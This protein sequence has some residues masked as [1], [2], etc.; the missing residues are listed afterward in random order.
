[1]P[2]DEGFYRDQKTLHVVFFFSSAALLAATLWMFAADHFLPWKRW[3]REFN[4]VVK[5]EKLQ[6]ELS[7][8]EQELR[9]RR[10]EI[11]TL[12]QRLAQARASE[13][14]NA[15][16]TQLKS[17]LASLD[18]DLV[19]QDMA[20]QFAKADR[21]EALSAYDRVVQEFE[22]SGEIDVA[23]R[24]VLEYRR[25]QHYQTF[26]DH[27]KRVA[28]L[29]AV[30][31]AAKRQIRE[32]QDRL[33]KLEKPRAQI[34][35]ELK[36]KQ[37]Q[38]RKLERAIESTVF[39][40]GARL[41]GL[42]ILDAFAAPVKPDQ[43]VLEDL[44]L[45]YNFKYVTRHDRCRTCH[46]GIDQD[47]YT[48]EMG[49]KHPFLSHPH[50]DL[51]VGAKSP[52][53]F[54]KFG[55]TICH[56]GQGTA[57]AF[58]WS[59]HSPN[60]S[61]QMK[62]WHQRHGWFFNHFHELPMFP[63]RFTESGCIQCHHDPHQFAVAEEKYGYAIG[64]KVLLGYETVRTYGCFGCHEISGF[65]DDGTAI[66]PHLR[67]PLRT[68][69]PPMRRRALRRVGP[70]LMNVREKLTE[71]FVQK[72][73]RDPLAFRPT[74]RMPTFY[75]QLDSG[76]FGD[77]PEGEFDQPHDPGT[78]ASVEIHAIGKYLFALSEPTNY[79]PIGATGNAETGKKL[80]VE[81][82]CLACHYHKEHPPGFTRVR[83]PFAPELSEIGAKFTTDSQKR[84]LAAW[85][86]DPS[87]FNPET[88]MPNTQLTDQEAADIAAYLLGVPG[89]WQKNVSLPEL[90]RAALRDLIVM[91]ESKTGSRAEANEVAGDV[92]K[93]RER[94]ARLFD[95]P[96]SVEPPPPGQGIDTNDLVELQLLY[97]GHKTIARLGCFGCHAIPG[98]KYERDKSGNLI[99][100]ADGSP[101][102]EL[103]FDNTKPIGTTLN[104][105]GRKDTHQLAFENV[106]EYV[107]HKMEAH[108]ENELPAAEREFYQFYAD[109]DYYLWAMHEHQRDGF[110]MQKLREPR[111]Y[112]YQKVR[113]WDD[114][115]RMP[116]F[117]FTD[118]QRE[119][120]AT[121]I[122]GLFAEKLP[123]Q[124]IYAP[125]PRTQARIEGR[126]LL[127]QYNCV[128]C[129]VIRPAEYRATLSAEAANSLIATAKANLA[130]DFSFPGHSA[131]EAKPLNSTNS[132]LARGL[133]AGRLVDTEQG[134]SETR[135]QLWEATSIGNQHIPAGMVVL[136][137][138]DSQRPA[139]F[140]PPTGG[141]FALELVEHLVRQSPNPENPEERDKAWQ[142]A[143]PPLIREGEKV[144]TPWLYGFLKDPVEIRP[145]TLLRMPK[146]NFGQGHA[147]ALAD[148]FAAADGVAYPYA[149]VAE[150]RESYLIERERQY[151]NY[152][153]LGLRLVAHKD[154]CVKCHPIAGY[155]PTGKPEEKGPPLTRAHERLRPDWML[156]WIT[157]PKRLVP[158]TQM[159]VNFQKSGEG[160]TP[161]MMAILPT[162]DQFERIR[163]VRDVL[164]NY[165]RVTEDLIPK[166]QVAAATEQK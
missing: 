87:A 135:V 64:R 47:G 108:K 6:D 19:R 164:V 121:F 11:A 131:W 145:G 18:A 42:P 65:A 146:F 70:T 95:L 67:L 23:R 117:N 137:P 79:Q 92:G 56:Q 132:L 74:T 153:Q 106:V 147:E 45:N 54:E 32:R 57:T 165:P 3:Q 85:I 37:D 40:P 134:A 34:E 75:D 155:Q 72:W 143:P 93:L 128:A 80:F 33:E 103:V 51:F 20:V 58:D 8:Q 24:A 144:Q 53:K 113:R 35:E 68:D 112:D 91:F 31:D 94:I 118:E 41:R 5:R 122:L 30:V 136:L 25:D 16:I 13:A 99:P 78:L 4:S 166:P 163:A 21:Q 154:L 130:A 97:V 14:N 59:S 105:W 61:R 140:A 60:D 81:K 29:Q 69:S 111:S 12:E 17:E 151:K 100:V 161:D 1:M 148:Y 138:D 123:R 129:H 52:H 2:A 114:R 73:I 71:E 48:A 116:R 86:K 149:E 150:R 88:Y 46:V 10:D 66:G 101:R 139:Q 157:N 82:G 55:C 83:P 22:G 84:W 62:E 119:S 26:L 125:D 127:E 43:V 98:R 63:K 115:A 39:T 96:G 9:T 162:N 159:P 89:R 120:V 109:N 38:K 158:Y 110:L 102:Y 160:M 27:E 152:L 126:R 90:D 15:E 104:N 133:F 142:K 44:R 49:L 77:A 28:E 50:L 7:K 107:H 156:R 36:K 76:F 124:Y 141:K